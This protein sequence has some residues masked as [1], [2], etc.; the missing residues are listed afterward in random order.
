MKIDVYNIEGKVVDNIELNDAYF[1]VPLNKD[2]VLQYLRYQMF[3]ARWPWAHV[4]TRGEVR[5]GG[6]KP[7]RQKGTGRARQGSIRSPQW[8]GGGVV[9]GPRNTIN[10]K[11]KMP[12]KM[13]RKALLMLL[14]EKVKENNIKV[15]SNFNDLNQIKTKLA[16]DI[17]KNLNVY[18]D[19]VLIVLNNKNINV[20]KSF[21]NISNVKTLLVN[22][23]NPK[24]LMHYKM[25]LIDNAAI[26]SIYN[27][28]K[29]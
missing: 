11:L 25:L 27:L 7:W 12:K 18:N 23:I 6:R 1:N 28:F 5:G 29:I 3:N 16:L 24:D 22:Y 2:L 17:L 21:A 15:I 9:F 20:E 4:K 19:K 14:S 26:N 10:W 13:R 8:R